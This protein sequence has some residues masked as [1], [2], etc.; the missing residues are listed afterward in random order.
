[1]FGA[2]DLHLKKPCRGTISLA[3]Q[4]PFVRK[5][6]SEGA[7][8]RARAVWGPRR[9]HCLHGARLLHR[10]CNHYACLQAHGLT[11]SDT[12][13]SD[14]FQAL[15]RQSQRCIM[16]GSPIPSR[17]G[18]ERMKPSTE[19]MPSGCTPRPFY[20]HGLG[21]NPPPTGWTGRRIA[22]GKERYVTVRPA[23][24]ERGSPL[25]RYA[26]DVRR[27]HRLENAMA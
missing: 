6:W 2:L 12:G 7:F 23:W 11:M 26:E 5:L 20:S 16:T 3:G 19:R 27:G 21:T 1:M 22:D 24:R 17:P 13:S 10:Q 18:P 4:L 14:R 9:G 15:T 8:E 25:R